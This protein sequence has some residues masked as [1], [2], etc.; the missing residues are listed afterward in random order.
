LEPEVQFLRDFRDRLVLKTFAGSCF[1]RAFNSFYYS[2][3]PRVARFIA[4]NS[5]LRDVMKVLLCPLL[6]ILRA[7]S[8]AYQAF[9]FNSE[10]AVVMAGLIASSLIGITYVS[11]LLLVALM[12]KRGKAPVRMR[13]GPLLISLIAAA[14]LI[15]LGTALSCTI[16]TIIATSSFVLLA[17]LLS[18]I[19]TAMKAIELLQ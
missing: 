18:G 13:F 5:M 12:I 3:S 10:L 2:F 14:M 15:F 6:G 7:S 19:V 9:G 1:M 16:V 8:L 17:L 4:G 11:P